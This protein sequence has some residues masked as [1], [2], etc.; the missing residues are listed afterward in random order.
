MVSSTN[1]AQELPVGKSLPVVGMTEPYRIVTVASVY[2]ARIAEILAD[3]GAFV[4]KGEIVVQF[5]DGVQRARTALAQAAMNTTLPVDLE[6]ARLSKAQREVARL[7]RLHG[8]DFASSKE[9][10]DA[11]AQEE[12]LRV[13]YDLAVFNQKQAALG[14]D[15]ERE[16]LAEYQLRSPFPAYV[17]AHVR[18]AGETVE[19][20][21]GIVRLVQLD[22]LLVT[23]DCPLELAHSI[24]TGDRYLVRPGDP[25]WQPRQASVVFVSRVADAASQTFKVKLAVDNKDN[26]WMAGMRVMVDF[27]VDG[28]RE[29]GDLGADGSVK[30]EPERTAN[31][32]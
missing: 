17:A 21:D 29:P 9:L 4:A 22:P 13:E 12:I 8:D 27:A 26:G 3:E 7:K 28:A 15:R 30:A 1:R 19:P 23:V 25:Q 5:E 31:S 32:W 16:T 10:A 2:P 20:M 14:Y 18:Y 11:L 6:R 24:S